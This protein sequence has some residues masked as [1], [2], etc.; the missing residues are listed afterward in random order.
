VTSRVVRALSA[1]V[2]AVLLVS[3]L[4]APPADAAAIDDP[5]DIVLVLDFS[6]SI[7]EDAAIRTDFADAL[8]GIAARVDAIAGELVAGDATVSIVRFATRA[9][10]VPD[11]TSLA[12]RENAPAVAAFADCLRRVAAD[13]R[14]GVNAAL[15]RAIGDDTNYVAAMERA[16]RHLPSDSVRPAIIFFTDGRHEA[17]GVDQADVLPARDR[18]FGD[19]SPFAL[20][21]V[22]MGLD[23]A[24][25]PTLEAGLESLRVTR[26]F[27]RCEGGALAWPNVVFESAD[28]AGQAVALALQDV[29]C[30][31][32]VEPTPTP[33][34]T[35]TPEPPSPVRSLRLES[36][37]SSVALSWAAPDDAETNPVEDYQVRCR[38][39]AE[40]EGAWIESGEGVST[41]TTATVKGLNNGVE[42]TCEVIAVRA[43]GPDPVAE[44]GMIKPFGRPPAPAKPTVSVGSGGA[45]LGVSVP[46]AQRVDALAYECSSDGGATWTLAREVSGAQTSLDVTGLTNGTE[47]VCRVFAS[48]E[49]GVSDASPL[50]DVFRPCSWLIDCN[51]IVLPL[52]GVAAAL[53]LAGLLL[54]LYRWYK[55]RQVYVTAQ[56]DGLASVSLGRGPT[57]RMRFVRRGPYNRLTGIAPAEGKD[58]DV[59]IRYTGGE[60]FEIRSKK[61]RA[62]TQFGRPVDVADDHGVVHSVIVRAFDEPPAP[63]RR[64]EDELR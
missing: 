54:V 11:C 58:A 7:L 41:E 14:R 39:T 32:T 1:A 35:P 52:F 30:T 17:A 16:A 4:P 59:R 47:Y 5:S 44:S 60:T 42:Y 2:V 20:L 63:L 18:L 24:A 50:T 53:I 31:F 45:R 9:Q 37:D 48:N 8:D 46:G 51:P 27:E 29:S 36:G 57:V 19:R 12:L 3:A 56:V 26:E 10:D 13:Y 43:G 49:S 28:A 21:P 40:P 6:G 55:G 23:P 22:G 34:P 38:P 15:I 64:S 62:K 25:R 33:I 61:T